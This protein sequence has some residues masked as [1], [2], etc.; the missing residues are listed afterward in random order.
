MRIRS[1]IV[2]A[3]LVVLLIG[4]G[5]VV[6]N[7]LAAL[8]KPPPQA[9]TVERRLRVEALRVDPLTVRTLLTGF[10][11]ARADRRVELIPQV[12]GRIIEVHPD[13]DVGRYID[14]DETLFRI[15]PRDYEAAVEQARAAL[16][17]LDAQKARL[18]QARENDQRRIEIAR[19]TLELARRDFERFRQLVEVDRVESPARMDQAET[20]MNQAREQVVALE[21]ALALYPAQLRDL[22]AQLQSARARLE[23]A[24]LDLERTRVTAP[25]TGRVDRKSIEIGQLVGPSMA[26]AVTL[27][28][29]AS[30]EIPVPLEGGEVARW[31]DV[32]ALPDQPTW[33]SRL[34]GR[35]VVIRWTEQPDRVQWAGRL[36]RIE[37]FDPQTR[38]VHVVARVT[39]PLDGQ[40]PAP[41]DFPLV[42]GMFCQ[43]EI[44]GREVAGVYRLPRSA[45]GPDGNVLIVNDSRIHSR[46]VHIA[47]YEGDTVLIDDGLQ[48][49]QI[50]LTTQPGIVLDG[51]LVDVDLVDPQ[52]LWD[53]AA[54][55]PGAP[56]PAPPI[57]RDE[58]PR[59]L[60]VTAP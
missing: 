33:F 20:A 23:Q 22:D 50:V 60:E 8:R 14:R 53:D 58:R 5:A 9:E 43:V 49:G 59:E 31:L 37:R 10:G 36:D 4:G 28:D 55:S 6:M 48:P 17:S 16:D 42:E 26:N 57:E 52:T 12:A 13:L 30:L 3:V 29:D 7:R 45:V 21:N 44:P 27:V 11:Q 54:A 25:F 18:A 46:A 51:T 2:R 47:R 15:D 41:S 38:T 34:E 56:V 32:Q 39:R 1:V 19:R 24:R 40:S 35:P